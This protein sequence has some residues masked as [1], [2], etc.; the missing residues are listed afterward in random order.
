FSPPKPVPLPPG[1]K[2]VKVKDIWSKDEN[3]GWTQVISI[4]IHAG[5]MVLLIVPFFRMLPPSAEAKNKLDVTPLDISPYMAK[6]PA[7]D[8][9]AGGGGGGNDRR[10]PPINKGKPPKCKMTQFPPPQVRPPNIDPNLP[11]DPSLLGPP[12][13]KVANANLPTFGDPLANGV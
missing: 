9:N 1:I 7:G 10:R 6:L 11:M 12:D 8:K 3:F 13:L 5:L 2:P 4:G